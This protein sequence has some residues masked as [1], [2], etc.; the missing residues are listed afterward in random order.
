MPNRCSI[1]WTTSSAISSSNVTPCST[2][3][4]APPP[5]R[6]PRRRGARACRPSSGAPAPGPVP[7]SSGERPPRSGSS[8]MGKARTSVGRFAE[9]PLVEL[10]DG[11]LVDEEERHLDVVRR[12]PRRSSTRGPDRRPAVDVDGMVGLFVGGEDVKRH[13]VASALGPPSVAARRRRR[14]RPRCGD[15]PR[16]AWSDGRR[17]PSGT[18]PRTC[19][20]PTRPERPPGTSIWVTSPVTTALEPKPMRVR[21]IFICSGVVFWASSRMMKLLLRVRP[22]MKASGATSMVPRSRSRW[23]PS[24]SEQVVQG[25]VE[26][27]QIGVDLGHDVAG[28]EPEPLAGLHRRAGQDDPLDLRGPAGPARPGPRPDTTCPCP[29]GRC[30]R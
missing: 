5:G 10:G 11:G 21:N 12:L 6:R 25:V 1:P 7:P 3:L 20:R 24:G 19:S 13:R 15:A 26:G 2:A 22:R 16:R 8:S 18:P 14:C 30:R 28:Q 17:P 23:A 9:E 29:P 4:R 27:A